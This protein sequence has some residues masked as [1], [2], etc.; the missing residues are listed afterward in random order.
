MSI[1]YLLLTTFLLSACSE[2]KAKTATEDRTSSAQ[3][4]VASPANDSLT[5]NLT[6][7]KAK[8]L[9]PKTEKIII[10]DDPVYHSPKTYNCVPLKDFLEKFSKVKTLDPNKTQLVFECE[11]G[12]NPSMSLA[13]VFS[14][15]AFLAVSDVD[16]PKGQDWITIV[17]DGHEKSAAPF[18]VVYQDVTSK[19][20]EFKWPY[21]LVRM[22]LVPVS[23]EEKAIFPHGDETMVKGY[24]LFRIN[25]LLCHAINKVGGKMGP[26]LNYPKSIT[27]YWHVEDIKA[28]IKNPK[29]YRND[30]KMPA[31]SYLKD[32]EIDEIVKYLQYMKGKSGLPRN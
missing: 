26:E 1:K 3:I 18:Y 10:A 14:R 5:I 24:D 2:K 23:E 27:E 15:K 21:N 25:C 13:K 12:Y 20:H 4:A 28:F 19:E 32:Q 17:K 31:V 7:L 29:A 11:D 30:C 8:G 9:I 22:R 16:A 6:D